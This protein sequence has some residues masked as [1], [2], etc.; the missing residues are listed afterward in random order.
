LREGFEGLVVPSKVYGVLAAGR[1]LIYQGNPEGEIARLV[2]EEKIGFALENGD[3]NS[4]AQVIST[5][6]KNQ[7]LAKKHGDRAYNIFKAKYQA[8]N[9]LA[10]YSNLLQ[11]FQEP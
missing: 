1:A 5:Y 7:N 8:E 10:A 11:Q 6:N 9:A 3:I 4:L 2:T